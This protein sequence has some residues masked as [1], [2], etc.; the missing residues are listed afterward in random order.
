MTPLFL[1][2]IPLAP[3]LLRGS[4]PTE[5]VFHLEV[6]YFRWLAWGAG[7]VVVHNAMSSFYTD[8]A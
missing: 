8:G 1:L 2:S 5:A 3:W 4:A 7:A 6:T